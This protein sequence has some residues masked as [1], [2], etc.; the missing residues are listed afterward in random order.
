MS[1]VYF[2][3]DDGVLAA[4]VKGVIEA[5]TQKVYAEVATL[6][7]LDDCNVVFVTNSARVQEGAYFQE[8]SG[9]GDAAFVFVA[10]A[11]N[12]A[13]EEDRAGV[14]QC[15]R[16]HLLGAFYLIARA[17][18]LALTSDCGLLEEVI[19]AGFAA[20]FV[21]A[22]GSKDVALHEEDASSMLRLYRALQDACRTGDEDIEGWFFGSEEKQLPPRAGVL[23]GTY[24]VGLYLEKT[25]KDSLAGLRTRAREVLAIAQV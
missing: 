22:H 11:V 24:L 16:D 14:A 17:R 6:L 21:R 23:L 4:S 12:T 2:L 25:G 8:S 10:E 7:S 3:K 9:D 20:H 13:I 19:D 1:V 5:L 15:L 18:H